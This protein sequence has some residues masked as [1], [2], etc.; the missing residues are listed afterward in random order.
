[1]RRMADSMMD[2]FCFGTPS[3]HYLIDLLYEDLINYHYNS[4]INP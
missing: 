3:V 2:R 4:N 1:M